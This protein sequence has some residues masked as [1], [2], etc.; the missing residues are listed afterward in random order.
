[1]AKVLR[2]CWLMKSEPEV[3]SIQ[4]LQ[5]NSRCA[6]EGVRNYQARNSMREMQPGDLVLFYHSNAKPSGVAG[7]ARVPPWARR[8]CPAAVRPVPRVRPQANGEG[9]R[10]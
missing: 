8:R 9:W 7:V 5:K 3:Y 6:W 2:A 1:M 10:S 4:D